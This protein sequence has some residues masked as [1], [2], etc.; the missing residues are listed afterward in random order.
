MHKVNY[1]ARSGQ[2]KTRWR[3]K[4][5]EGPPGARRERSIYA[6]TR[7]QLRARLAEMGRA[8]QGRAAQRAGRE[9]IRDFLPRWL[10]SIRSSVTPGTWATYELDVRE[11]IAPHLGHIE[12]G[13]LL[14]SDVDGWTSKLLERLAPRTVDHARATL[15]RA[16]RS[17]AA[18]QAIPRNPVSESRP[19]KIRRREQ[20]TWSVDE[21]ARFLDHCQ[22][23][24]GE[25]S[26][27]RR[28]VHRDEAMYVLALV[29]G[30]REGELLGLQV[31]RLDFRHKRIRI[32]AQLQE[33]DGALVL[34]PAKTDDSIRTVAMLPECEA[35][36]VRQL[37]SIEQMRRAA[38]P[39]WQDHGLVFPTRLG[40]PRRGS[41]VRATFHRARAAAGLKRIAFHDLR[42]TCATLLLE[43]GRNPRVVQ[44][45]L[46]H[47]DVAITLR[48]Y[49]HVRPHI[50]REAGEQLEQWITSRRGAS[51][52]ASGEAGG[53]GPAT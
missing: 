26:R 19:I 31:T 24:T 51:R 28:R 38:G 13:Q 4:V 12:A 10:G 18:D 36:L 43:Q 44:E 42:H 40:T 27:G 29:R 35:A 41:D 6:P 49:S 46:G 9:L 20:C 3:E 23:L 14:P 48:T 33:I 47:A 5:Y 8:E 2:I 25:T 53:K 30:M 22:G 15:R 50:E 7:A 17:L 1:R 16:F 21:V 11:R 52:G 37:A 34:V 39:R 32:D 45:L